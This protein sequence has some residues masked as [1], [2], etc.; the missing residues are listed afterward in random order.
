MDPLIKKLGLWNWRV[1]TMAAVLGTGVLM[2]FW[3]NLPPEVPLLYSRPWGEDQLVSP[4][5]LW[6]IPLLAGLVG[7]GLG[8]IAGKAQE[9]KILPAMILISSMVI[10]LIMALGLVK[11][12]LTV[13]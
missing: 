6:M 5:F 7:I 2:V 4:Y 3:K 8:A 11:I 12:I 1:V 10:Q 13:L 9:D